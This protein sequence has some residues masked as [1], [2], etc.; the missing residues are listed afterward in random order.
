MNQVVCQSKVNTFHTKFTPLGSSWSLGQIRLKSW[1]IWIC[2]ALQFQIWRGN[3]WTVLKH[4]DWKIKSIKWKIIRWK[5]WTRTTWNLQRKT[6]LC[7]RKL[8]GIKSS[9]KTRSK[10]YWKRNVFSLKESTRWLMNKTKL[11]W[12]F[13]E[14]NAKF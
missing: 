12:K 2:W 8:I 13:M 3:I 7:D 11:S 4:F 10:S 1:R 6:L 14:L 9:T 5:S